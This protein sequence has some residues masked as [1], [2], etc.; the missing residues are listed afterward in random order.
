MFSG[1]G[2]LDLVDAGGLCR[3]AIAGADVLLVRTVTRVDRDL[4]KGTRVRFV[5]TASSGT[6]HVDRE[7]LAS[8]DIGFAD[9][10]GCN[11]RAVC[12]Y[13]LSSLA[14][15]SRMRKLDLASVRVGI[16]GAGHVGSLL[17]RML[18]ALDIPC[19][20]N[21]PPLEETTGES[22]YRPLGELLDSDVLTFHVALTENGAHPTRAM[23]NDA[24]LARLRPDVCLINT[25]RGEILDEAA[26]MKF[27][28]VNPR[29]IA[30]LDVW[31][32]EPALNI[33]L[34]R[35]TDLGTAH[36][37]GYSLDA[38]LRATTMIRDAVCRYFGLEAGPALVPRLPPPATPDIPVAAGDADLDVVQSAILASYDVRTDDAQ[39]RALVEMNLPERRG[40]FMDLRRNYAFR[41]EFPSYR[42][43]AGEGSPSLQRKLSAVGFQVAGIG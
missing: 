30:V 41:R 21:D 25:S 28:D 38:K 29:A 33:E 1:L 43:A 34:L 2:S 7:W 15:L 14:S 36:I 8:N 27:I 20:L 32:G 11:A 42:V 22:I 24:F 13:V 37:A 6:D 9:A 23:L 26:L 17:G 4:L 16:I 31:P 12:E 19:L 35:R 3:D 40:Y 5:A 18:A 10:G 39:L